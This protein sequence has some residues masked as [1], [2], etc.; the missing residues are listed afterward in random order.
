MK[1]A[2]VASPYIPVNKHS[3]KGTEIWVYRYLKALKKFIQQ[4]KENIKITLFASKDSTKIFPLQHLNINASLKEKEIGKRHHSYFELSLL[5]KAFF[6]QERFDLYH[7]NFA[8]GEVVL[9]F[10]RF[11]KKPILITPHK[12]FTKSY[13]KKL[14]PLYQNLKNVFYIPISKRQ[15]NFIHFRK[16]KPILHGIETKIYQF[17]PKEGNYILFVGRAIPEKG[18]DLVFRITN[19][20]KVKTEISAIRKFEHL[21]W[22][23]K[24]KKANE[25]LIK[26]K[27]INISYE[28][29]E[30]ED[31]I[32]LLQKARLLIFPVR[33]EEPF[34]MVMIES[35][36]CGTPVVAFARGS[37]P[38][39]IKDGE[40]GF[41]VNPSDDD[42]RGQWLIKKT[43]VKGLVEAV[44]RIYSMPQDQYQKMRL[45]CRR[46]VEKNFTIERMVNDYIKTYR[47]ICSQ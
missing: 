38:E 40:T 31:I 2:I 24:L 39:V 42:L 32:P 9:P 35:M 29:P 15:S 34:G 4:T 20:L 43:G 7:I 14:F 33:Y 26:E 1:I 18:L 47:Q 8:A 27:L 21:E 16:L 6:Q 30:K 23:K 19:R 5:N 45:N 11:V 17:N 37:V 28:K 13:F 46:H 10:A 44:K 36:A 3:Q 12:I 41:I 25:S 22:F